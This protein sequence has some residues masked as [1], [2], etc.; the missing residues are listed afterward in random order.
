MRFEPVTLMG[1]HCSTQA[2]MVTRNISNLN[3]HD[4]NVALLACSTIKVLVF[5]HPAK[6]ASTYK[7]KIGGQ[8]LFCIILLV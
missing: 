5:R 3:F 4:L 6:I 8:N 7:P 2:I 1:G